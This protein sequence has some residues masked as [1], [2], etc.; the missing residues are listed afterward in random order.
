MG[1]L[2]KR[3]DPVV[4]LVNTL[5]DTL[6]RQRQDHNAHIET[7]VKQLHDQNQLLKELVDQY[8]NRGINTNESLH[9]R[10]ERQDQYVKEPEWGPIDDD[11]FGDVR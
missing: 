3:T 6:E 7:L 2:T 9:D 5:A 1:F 4:T 8:I 11:L 10:V